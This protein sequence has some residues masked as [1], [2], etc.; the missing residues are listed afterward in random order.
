MSFESC[1]QI[2]PALQHQANPPR[3]CRH[4]QF[5]YTAPCCRSRSDIGHR[6]KSPA[7]SPLQRPRANA[8]HKNKVP[9]LIQVGHFVV[10]HLVSPY[11]ITLRQIVQHHVVWHFATGVTCAESDIGVIPGGMYPAPAI[12]VYL[13]TLMSLR[14]DFTPLTLPARSAARVESA[15]LLTKPV[16]FTVP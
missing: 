5:I 12:P 10:L 11:S 8:L 14:T 13:L 2:L 7:I 9:N 3:G 15:S 4:L 16:S 1:R 6:V